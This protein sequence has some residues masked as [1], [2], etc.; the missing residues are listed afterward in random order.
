MLRGPTEGKGFC[1]YA[2]SKNAFTL[3]SEEK[4]IVGSFPKIPVEL[5]LFRM[6]WIRHRQVDP[7]MERFKRRCRLAGAIYDVKF[8]LGL[9]S[10][11]H[12]ECP[13]FWLRWPDPPRSGTSHCFFSPP[14]RSPTPRKPACCATLIARAAGRPPG[15]LCRDGAVYARQG[16]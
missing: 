11:Q 6:S 9:G 8:F 3:T 5:S 14:P 4:K 12:L 7:V 13:G 2:G 10:Q 16:W 1:G 15:N